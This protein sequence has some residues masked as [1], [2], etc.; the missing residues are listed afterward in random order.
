MDTPEPLLGPSDNVT[1]DDLE[2]LAMMS[3]ATGCNMPPDTGDDD[4]QAGET[5]D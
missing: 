2:A 3:N 1:P 4:V 5:W